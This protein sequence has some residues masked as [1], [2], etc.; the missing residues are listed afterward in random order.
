MSL[1]ERYCL[2]H[3]INLAC[4]TPQIQDQRKEIIPLAYGCVVELGMGSGLNLPYY[5]PKRVNQL[6]GVEPS[7]GMY[8][9]A[10]PNL[11]NSSIPVEWL[12]VPAEELPLENAS[13]DTAV[14]TYTLC[15][16][17]N[18][19]AV[20]A[21]VKRVLK[22]DGI[23]LFSEHGLAPDSRVAKWQNRLNPLWKTFAGGCHLNRSVPDCLAASGFRIDSLETSYLLD[24]PK[25]LGFNYRGIAR[26]A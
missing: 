11:I 8:E 24:T 2:P 22:P 18:W 10:R 15:S 12:N 13:V 16:I 4:G 19:K 6:W 14:L 9:K 17:Q 3:L 5:D 20:L 26:A 1:Y 7:L 23:L 21:Q 25:I